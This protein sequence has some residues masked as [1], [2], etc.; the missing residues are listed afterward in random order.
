VADTQAVRFTAKATKFFAGL[1]RDNSKT[2]G[3]RTS[4]SSRTRSRNRWL[5]SWIRCQNGSNHSRFSG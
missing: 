4:R 5:R 3:R 2:T 1:E